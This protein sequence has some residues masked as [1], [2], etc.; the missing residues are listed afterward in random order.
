[1]AYNA[2][3]LIS[4]SYN[5]SGIVPRGFGEPTGAQITDGLDALNDILSMQRIN[6]QYIPYYGKYTFNTVAGQ[7]EYFVENLVAPETFTFLLNSLRYAS[8]KVGRDDY[9][10]TFRAENINSLMFEWHPEP[11][12]NGTRI[13]V[14][15][16]PNNIYTVNIVG[17]FGFT[18]VTLDTNLETAY[19]RFY[20]NYLKYFLA[21]YLCNENLSP[22]PEFVLQELKNIQSALVSAFPQDFTL[23]KTSAMG[24]FTGINWGFVNLAARGGGWMP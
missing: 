11:E 8:Y 15:F 12:K 5:L 7:E 21:Y 10:G 9:F 4:K 18:N 24:N 13:Y 20:I 1:M 3:K 17:K 23:Q 14:Y 2:R 22:V 16:K 19:D 6:S